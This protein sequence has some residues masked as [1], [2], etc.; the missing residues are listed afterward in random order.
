M[1]PNLN[2]VEI[3]QL[4]EHLLCSEKVIYA[5]KRLGVLKAGVHFYALGNISKGG[6]HIYCVELCRQ[7]LLDETA[8]QAKAE[9]EKVKAQEVYNQSHLNELATSSKT[10]R[11]VQNESK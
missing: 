7:A 1:N 5:A 6:K 4:R 2:W 3:A 9:S 8:K 10:W 11:P